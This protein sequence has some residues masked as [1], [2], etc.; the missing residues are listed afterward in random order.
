M[1]EGNW[2]CILAGDLGILFQEMKPSGIS[3]GNL[4]IPIFTKSAS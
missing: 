2:E 4:L 3:S 1:V